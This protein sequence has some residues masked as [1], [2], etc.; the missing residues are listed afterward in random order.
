MTVVHLHRDAASLDRHF[1]A[2][3]AAFGRFAELVELCRIDVY[4]DPSAEARAPLRQKADLLG[5][6]TVAIHPFEAGFLCAGG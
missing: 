3:G 2:A 1:E 5:G 4:G 6:A